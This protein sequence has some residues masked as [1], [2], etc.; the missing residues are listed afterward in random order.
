MSNVVIDGYEINARIA[1]SQRATVYRAVQV[2]LDR[3][4]SLK[5]LKPS[6]A[7]DPVE[8]ARFKLESA[9]TTDLRN[10]NIALCYD[11]G[12]S[13]GFYYLSTEYIGGSTLAKRMRFGKALSPPEVLIIMKSVVSALESA[14]NHGELIHLN[15]KPSNIMI[16]NDGIVKVVDFCG[17]TASSSETFSKVLDFKHARNAI[18][19]P[20]ELAS[21]WGRIDFRADIYGL[22]ALCY[23]M[24][25]GREP[26]AGAKIAKNK[27]AAGMIEN[28]LNL[29]PSIPPEMAVM[30]RKMMVID[31]DGRYQ[32]WDEINDDIELVIDNRMPA[33]E[34]LAQYQCAVGEYDPKDKSESTLLDW[35][36][37]IN[38]NFLKF[39]VVVFVLLNIYLLYLLFTI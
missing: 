13:N 30:I 4:V 1:E 28:P 26:L 19:L 24:L 6:L 29:K 16:A 3:T 11:S 39:C 22:G 21:D 31:P 12:C 35:I 34:R 38:L 14:W 36:G 23:H 2:S 5:V 8:L 33:S 18:Y 9:A 10:S 15:I 25:T 20:P 27:D 7:Q 37:G 32:S 17:L